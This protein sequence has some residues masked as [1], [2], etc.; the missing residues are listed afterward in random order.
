MTPESRETKL[1]EKKND[2]RVRPKQID[3]LRMFCVCGKPISLTLT[4]AGIRPNTQATWH[5]YCR[6]CS[7][8]VYLEVTSP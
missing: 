3:T 4:R 2:L 8:H 6:A 1:T 5:T 7:R